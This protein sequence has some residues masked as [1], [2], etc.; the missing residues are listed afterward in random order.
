MCGFCHVSKQVRCH[1]AK[2]VVYSVVKGVLSCVGLCLLGS[3]VRYLKGSL[4][5]MSGF[6]RGRRWKK[7]RGAG[8]LW[9]AS[10]GRVTWGRGPQTH[11]ADASSVLRSSSAGKMEWLQSPMSQA[12]PGRATWGRGPQTHDADASFVLRSS[13]AGERSRGLFCVEGRSLDL[14]HSEWCEAVGIAYILL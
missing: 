7:G 13:S 9:R 4:H 3:F 11:D 5:E 6:L 12:S 2:G 10:P 8:P 14:P 1:D